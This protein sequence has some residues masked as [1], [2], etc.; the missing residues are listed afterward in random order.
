MNQRIVAVKHYYKCN[1]QPTM[2]A[3]RLAQEFDINSPQGRNI[4]LIVEKFEATRATAK[5][6]GR[7]KTATNVAKAEEAIRRLEQSLQKLTRRL[8]AEFEVS[9]SGVIHILHQK[10]GNVT[11]HPYCMP[12]MMEMTTA[13]FN[14]VKSSSLNF[15]KRTQC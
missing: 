10:N 3:H 13:V 5:K 11:F 8:S 9:Q 1:E 15:T 4:R 12:F 2:A 6:S 7:P 14:F